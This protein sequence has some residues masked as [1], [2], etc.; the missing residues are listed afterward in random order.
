[1]NARITDKVGEIQRYVHELEEFMPS[2]FHDYLADTKTKAACERYFE[3]IVEAIVDGAMLLI[4]DKH[5]RIPEEDKMA[6][7]VLAEESIILPDLAS[8][9]KDAK[10]MRNILAHQYGHVDDE[11]VFHSITEE[12][13]EDANRFIA[14]ITR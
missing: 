5:L 9:L 1:M 7:D 4:K 8:R 6:F 3:K 2:T 14:A 11:T 10:G 12:L 13:V